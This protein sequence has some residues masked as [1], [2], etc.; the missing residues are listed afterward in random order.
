MRAIR[1]FI[2]EGEVTKGK[3]S[4]VQGAGTFEKA[5]QGSVTDQVPEPSAPLVREEDFAKQCCASRV[6]W[7]P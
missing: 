7:R 2:K 3:A 5:A 6:I 4:V 1:L